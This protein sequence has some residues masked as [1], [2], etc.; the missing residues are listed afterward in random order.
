MSKLDVLQISY[1][2]RRYNTAII[3]NVFTDNNETIVIG[4]H[5]LNSA[6][7]DEEKGYADIEAQYIDEYIYAFL[8]D[9][10]FKLSCE[11]FIKI[12]KRNLD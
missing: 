1:R 7:Y 3:P 2:N 5:S 9:D 10:C 11:E 6:L 12:A 4:C 8:D